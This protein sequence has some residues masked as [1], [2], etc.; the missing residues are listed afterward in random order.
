MCGRQK[1]QNPLSC[2]VSRLTRSY[3]PLCFLQHRYTSCIAFSYQPQL[4]SK[5][6][7]FSQLVSVQNCSPCHICKLIYY[8]SKNTLQLFLCKHSALCSKQNLKSST[9]FFQR[10]AMWVERH[11]YLHGTSP[12]AQPH[13]ESLLFPAKLLWVI[14]HF[15]QASWERN[16]WL[17]KN[18]WP[19]SLSSGNV[20]VLYMCILNVS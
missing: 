19:I 2:V 12:I 3:P 14:L 20:V 11:F 1:F 4:H 6:F 10:S 18:W 17:G 9:S 8:R 16:W 13:M 7:I 15:S 5:V